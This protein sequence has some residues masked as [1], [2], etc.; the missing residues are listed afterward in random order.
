MK[1]A[2]GKML[3]MMRLG[4]ERREGKVPVR[5]PRHGLAELG[6]RGG[7]PRGPRRPPPEA[8]RRPGRQAQVPPRPGAELRT[9]QP[10]FLLRSLPAGELPQRCPF[11]R[12]SRVRLRLRPSGGRGEEGSRRLP[13]I[14]LHLSNSLQPCES[15]SQFGRGKCQVVK[16][17]VRGTSE[18][19]PRPS[20]CA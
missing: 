19:G 13:E 18:S 10:F 11:P 5:A 1:A 4:G 7:G 15:A 16:A 2:Q 17:E 20:F 12:P 8:A 3:Q 14:L 9:P 6:G